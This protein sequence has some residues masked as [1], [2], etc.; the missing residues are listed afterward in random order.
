MS[1]IVII[2]IDSKIVNFALAKVE[3]Y[4]KM[5]GD[6]IVW[7]SDVFLPYADKIYVSCIFTTNRHQTKFYEGYGALIGGTGY[8]VN[9]TLPEEI[10]ILKPRI[11]YG[12]TTRGCIRNCSFCFVPQKEGK[13]HVIGDIYDIW[14]GKSKTIT[15]MDNNITALEWHFIQILRQAQKEN[16]SID[17]NQGIDF[18]LLNEKMISEMKK[19]KL[20]EIRLAL[21]N[22]RLIPQFKDKLR[23][24]RQYYPKKAFFVY[25]F[26][27]NRKGT[28][29][30]SAMKRIE[31]LKG[32]DCRPYLMR[33]DSI[34]ADK[35]WIRLARWVNQPSLLM[36]MTYPQFLEADRNYGNE[37]TD[38]NQLKLFNI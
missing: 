18:R 30:D 31:F 29:W 36:G 26:G 5:R 20:V 3:M 4:H 10:E 13:I 8:D 28:D 38:K 15:L 2:D 23:L 22:E 32:E 11:N 17:F 7:N 34:K 27:E 9:V 37:I 16:I 24:L 6:E 1:K 21:D 25:V 35:E 14:D 12:F 33:H 19:T